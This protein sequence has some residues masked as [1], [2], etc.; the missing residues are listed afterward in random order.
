[1]KTLEQR[2]AEYA[3]ARMRIF[4]AAGAEPEADSNGSNS[5]GMENC[6]E[7]ASE[8]YVETVTGLFL[9]ESCEFRSRL[10]TCLCTLQSV[11]LPSI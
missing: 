7:P 4:G 9:G 3:E 6:A 2:E 1:M 5:V 11:L 10:R 8:M